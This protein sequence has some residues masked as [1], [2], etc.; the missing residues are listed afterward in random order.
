MSA[1]EAEVAHPTLRLRGLLGVAEPS[2]T[3]G[4]QAMGEYTETSSGPV[5]SGA[6]RNGLS[7][8]DPH[9]PIKLCE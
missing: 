5:A 1:S 6:K 2:L 7:E 9:V 3:A 8:A 4:G